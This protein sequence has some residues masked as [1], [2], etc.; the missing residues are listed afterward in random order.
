MTTSE[1]VR[2]VLAEEVTRQRRKLGEVARTAG[3]GK[4]TLYRVVNLGATM[5]V[6]TLWAL[7]QAL[8]VPVSEIAF[9]A[10]QKRVMEALRTTDPNPVLRK[11][12]AERVR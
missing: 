7:A 12:L 5:E 4:N 9:R 8:D 11:A 1:A 3:V 6:P 10:D 2:Q